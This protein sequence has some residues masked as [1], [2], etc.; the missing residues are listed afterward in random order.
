MRVKCLLSVYI[1]YI[2]GWYIGCSVIKAISGNFVLTFSFLGRGLVDR[3]SVEASSPV[4]L[5]LAVP[6]RLFCFGS[7]AVLDVVCGYLLFFLLYVK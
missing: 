2:V 1:L 4:I 5:L 6:R 7:L 3:K